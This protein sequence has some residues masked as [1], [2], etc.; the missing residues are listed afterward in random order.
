MPALSLDAIKSLKPNIS[1]KVPPELQQHLN[2]INMP[3]L[4]E[5]KHTKTGIDF[6]MLCGFSIPIITICAFIILQIFLQLLNIIF[7]WLPYVRICIPFPKPPSP[8]P[9]P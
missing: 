1:V 9:G 4:L 2:R 3:D 7:F 8:P 5:G 6:G